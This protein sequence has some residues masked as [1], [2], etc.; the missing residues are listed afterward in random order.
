M[1][2]L[3]YWSKGGSLDGRP[4][5]LLEFDYDP[6]ILQRLKET[7][8]SQ[9]REWRPDE[10]RWWISEEYERVINDLFPGFLEAVKS[11]RRLFK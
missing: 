1:R 9:Y 8:P 11:Q 7:I 5:Y 4:G 10:K 6:D 3:N 2:G